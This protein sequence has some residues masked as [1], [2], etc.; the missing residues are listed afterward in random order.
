M[1]F[2]NSVRDVDMVT[3]RSFF[4]ES[5][6]AKAQN[7]SSNSSNTVL[8]TAFEVKCLII[9]DVSTL[10]SKTYSIQR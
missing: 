6:C 8:L 10:V 4:V 9:A 2:N 3:S 1:L 5:D 7:G